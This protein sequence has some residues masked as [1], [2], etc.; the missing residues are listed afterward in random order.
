MHEQYP[1]LREGS[2]PDFLILEYGDVSGFVSELLRRGDGVLPPFDEERFISHFPTLESLF[3]AYASELEEGFDVS[4]DAASRYRVLAQR[5][6]VWQEPDEVES[7]LIRIL[8]KVIQALPRKLVDLEEG[9]RGKDLLDPFIVAFTSR[10]LSS[11]S[12]FDLLR[13]LIAHK[14]MMKLE[15]LIGNLHQEALG[16]AADAQRVP[17]PQGILDE[18]GNRNKE[19]WHPTLNPFP[20]ADARRGDKEFYQIKNKTGSAKG[21]DADKLGRQFQTLMEKYPN[22]QGYYISM[23]GRTLKG[24]RSMGGFLRKAPDAEVLVGLAAFQQ[25]G[26]HRDTPDIAMNLY[27]EAF[28]AALLRNHYDFEQIVN[29]MTAEW[30]AKHGSEDPAFGMLRDAIMPLDPRDQSSKTYQKRYRI[31][32]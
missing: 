11:G 12:S 19:E 5:L 14:C 2:P 26:R 28:E 27:L 21:S 25:L 23:V 16:R 9:N 20:G 8:D 6:L 24:H 29:E 17:E 13:L 10:L 1:L 18:V 30:T 15:D 3:A 32:D 7:V 31:P 4:T 22:S